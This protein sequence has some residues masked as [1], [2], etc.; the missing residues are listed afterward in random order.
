MFLILICLRKITDYYLKHTFWLCFA[1]LFIYLGYGAYGY[2]MLEKHWNDANKAKLE[3]LLVKID[4]YQ[5]VMP[6]FWN[7]MVSIAVL[8]SAHTFYKSI[9]DILYPDLKLFDKENKPI[10]VHL[11]SRTRFLV[12]QSIVVVLVLLY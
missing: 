8:F 7:L 11:S 2:I 3:D 10:P 1:S 6:S 12:W 9:R 5:L 4:V